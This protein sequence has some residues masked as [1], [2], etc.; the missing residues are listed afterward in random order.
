MLDVDVEL[1]RPVLEHLAFQDRVSGWRST[2]E[3]GFLGPYWCHL[4]WEDTLK[5][6]SRMYRDH[7]PVAACS[8]L[9]LLLIHYP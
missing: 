9:R 1:V 3:P 2:E 4:T 6:I 7:W 8:G 5:I